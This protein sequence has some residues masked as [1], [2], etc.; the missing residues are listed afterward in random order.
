MPGRKNSRLSL[1]RKIPEQKRIME[2]SKERDLCFFNQLKELSTLYGKV[3]LAVI[4]TETLDKEHKMYIAPINQLRCALD[5]VFVGINQTNDEQTAYELKEVKEHLTRAGYDA[6]EL[7]TTIIGEQI[8]DSL[9]K[10]DTET[11]STVFPDY[12]KKIKPKLSNCQNV[13]AKLRTEKKT[14]PKNR[15]SNILNKSKS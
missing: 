9:H 2:E 13:V 10:Y 5:H 7:L 6:L 15:F 14:I 11:L 8:I 4:L 3:K 12:Y 1:C